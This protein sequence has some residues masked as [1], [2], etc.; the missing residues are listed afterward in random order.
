MQL[1]GK[2]SELTVG[3]AGAGTM[4]CATLDD[5]PLDPYGGDRGRERDRWGAVLANVHS[6]SCLGLI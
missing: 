5:I 3:G 4:I 2:D 1:L 6:P